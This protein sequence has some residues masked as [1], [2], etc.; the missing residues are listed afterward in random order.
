MKYAYAAWW[1]TKGAIYGLHSKD[2]PSVEDGVPGGN[3]NFDGSLPPGPPDDPPT[4]NT[5]E[6][7]RVL[8]AEAPMVWETIEDFFQVRL[9]HSF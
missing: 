8:E 3:C 5:A 7:E 6:E 1:T 9:D 4:E 2:L